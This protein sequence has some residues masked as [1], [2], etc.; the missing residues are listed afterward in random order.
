MVGV[1]GSGGAE[2]TELS[3]EFAGGLFDAEDDEVLE[4]CHGQK[5]VKGDPEVT[6]RGDVF[7]M[8]GGRGG[9]LFCDVEGGGGLPGSRE[10]GE[11]FCFVCADFDAA[12]FAPALHFVDHVLEFLR[13]CAD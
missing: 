2:V 4:G 7:E 6:K 8:G 10:E 12:Q 11:G 5:R 9:E 13:V 3:L 1:E